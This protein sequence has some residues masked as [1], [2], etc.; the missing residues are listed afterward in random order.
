MRVSSKELFST[1]KNFLHDSTLSPPLSTV[2][3]E[4][5]AGKQIRAAEVFLSVDHR[6]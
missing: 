5:V 1:L 4:E 6:V 3:F 2:E